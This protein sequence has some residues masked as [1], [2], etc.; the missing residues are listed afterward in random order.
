MARAGHPRAKITLEHLLHV[1]SGLA[2]RASKAYAVYFGGADALAEITGAPLEA[3]P[4]RRW[5]H[6]NRDTLL[7]VRAM[8]RAIGDDPACWTF[9]CRALLHRIG[10][11]RTIAEME[12]SGN[13]VPSSQVLTTGRDLA[14]FGLLHLNDGVWN[15]AQFWLLGG[16]PSYPTTPTP[17]WEAAGSSS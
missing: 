3:E 1:S 16:S 2:A 8:R 10:M 11:R 6:A 9:P 17:R 5:H 4:G 14:R 12:S 13:F 15:G 7:L